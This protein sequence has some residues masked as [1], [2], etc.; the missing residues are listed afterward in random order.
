MSIK[1]LTM[2]YWG[3]HY[4]TTLNEAQEYMCQLIWD[5]VIV[6]QKY[7]GETTVSPESALRVNMK[8]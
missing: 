8:A 1:A 3:I 4:A 7:S 2:M 5:Q 6:R